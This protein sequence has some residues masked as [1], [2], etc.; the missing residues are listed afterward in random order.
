MKKVTAFIASQQKRATYGA[1]REFGEHLKALGEV[2]FEVVFLKDYRLDYCRGCCACFEKGEE[3]CPLKDDR[4]L[5][6]QKIENSDGVIFASPTYAFQVAAPMKTMLDRFSFIL[7]RPRF[8]GKAFTAIAAQ[9]LHGGGNVVKY[10]CGI[11][12]SM[13]FSVTRGCVLQTLEPS[14]EA[15]RQKNTLKLKKAAKRFSSG[16][17]RSTPPSP[18]LFRLML[19]RMSRTGIKAML[20]EECRDYR[21]YRESGWF[22]GDYYYP[23]ALGPVKKTAGL[24]FDFLGGQM[25]KHR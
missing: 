20:G 25:V 5:L 14:T 6:L 17:A 18:S 12:K 3:R 21:H 1:V 2:D 16:L 19:F 10:L 4:D 8:F 13:G 11:G 15:S 23:V 9:G 24:M 22:E 7:H